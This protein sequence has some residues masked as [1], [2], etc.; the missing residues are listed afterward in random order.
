[1]KT[2]HLIYLAALG[3]GFL[4]ASSASA[5]PFIIRVAVGPQS[6]VAL[7]PG[8]TA[9]YTVSL[10][11]TNSGS[12]D[13]YLSVSNLPSGATASF[14]PSPVVFSGTSSVKNSTLSITTSPSLA[15]GTYPFSVISQDGGSGKI[16]TGT[17]TLIVGNG[18]PQ[19]QAPFI[20]S[21]SLLSDRTPQIVVKGTP[22]ASYQIL[23]TANLGPSSWTSVTTN[24]TGTNGLFSFNDLN[25]TQ[26]PTRFYRAATV[27]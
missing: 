13:A 8:G 19:V 16:C 4:F 11:K 25:S 27:Q 3:V 12:I 26:Y 5:D 22:N 24:V 9:T 18:A 21:I 15:D 14:S 17:G 6:P 10:T 23:A 7:S 1:M 20:V 2:Q